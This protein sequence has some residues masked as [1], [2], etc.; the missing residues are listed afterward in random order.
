MTSWDGTGKKLDEQK[1]IDG[2]GIWKQYF[3][4]GKINLISPYKGC[5]KNGIRTE[6]NEKGEKIKEETYKDG[7]VVNE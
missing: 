6:W 4:D 5:K 3:I 1:F 7:E 2:T